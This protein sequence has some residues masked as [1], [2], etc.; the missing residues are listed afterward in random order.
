MAPKRSTK[1]PDPGALLLEL[2][3][4]EREEREISALR[5]RLHDRLDAFP[6]DATARHEREVSDRRR[7]IHG[8]IAE[9]RA[10]LAPILRTPSP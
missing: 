10:T 6:N 4:L 8:R 9:L 1:P 7:A 5:R 2:E 3:Q